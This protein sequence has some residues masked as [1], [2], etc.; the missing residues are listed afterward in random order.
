MNTGTNLI[1]KLLSNLHINEQLF[2]HTVKMNKLQSI[3]NKP[4]TLIIIMY[5][6]IFNW[7]YSIKKESYELNVN[8]LTD[9]INFLG[10]TYQNTIDIYNTYYRNYI[11]LINIYP[12]IV[13]LDYIKLIDI[14]S[15]YSYLETKLSPFKLNLIN[16]TKFIEILN[17]PSKSHGNTVKNANEATSK[18]E[19]N[20]VM[21]KQF[22]IKKKP[23]LI[24][25]IDLSIIQYFEQS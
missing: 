7:L 24:K 20:K 2:K 15:G 25:D 1:T 4:N 18:Y 23:K 12:N 17:K 5:K 14:K 16:E 9:K 8:K 10:N 6:N 19:P 22:L 3:A 11:Q 21:V 13:W